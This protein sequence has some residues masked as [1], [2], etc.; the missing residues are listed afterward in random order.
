MRVERSKVTHTTS[1]TY[2][3]FAYPSVSRLCHLC[4]W[5]PWKDQPNWKEGRREGGREGG[6]EREHFDYR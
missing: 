4:L 6:R 2:F 1:T 5:D 3:S